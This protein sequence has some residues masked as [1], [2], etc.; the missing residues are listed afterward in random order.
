MIMYKN[1]NRRIQEI[2]LE[3]YVNTFLYIYNGIN[4]IKSYIKIK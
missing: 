1:L 4:K 3:L 2:I